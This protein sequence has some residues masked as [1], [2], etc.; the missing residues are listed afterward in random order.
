MRADR[1]IRQHPP[2]KHTICKQNRTKGCPAAFFRSALSGEA[3]ATLLREHAKGLCHPERSAMRGVEPRGR[4]PTRRG[5]TCYRHGILSGHHQSRAATRRESV[6]TAKKPSLYVFAPL[7]RQGHNTVAFAVSLQDPVSPRAAKRSDAH[8]ARSSTAPLRCALRM[9]QSFGFARL[10][11]FAARGGMTQPPTF[12]QGGLTVA[13]AFGRSRSPHRASE[14]KFCVILSGALCAESNLE[15]VHRRGV[16][17]PVAVTGSCRVSTKAA[18]RHA[19]RVEARG[20][21]GHRRF[22]E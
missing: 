5:G 12:T 17:A 1:E 6:K 8:S 14:S 18:R 9:T 13:Q 3:A 11:R 19:A 2:K 21:Y 7:L 16:A 20:G 15:G 10:L 4:A 22:G